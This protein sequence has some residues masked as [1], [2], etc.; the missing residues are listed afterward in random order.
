MKCFVLE[1]EAKKRDAPGPERCSARF[2]GSNVKAGGRVLRRSHCSG[3]PIERRIKRRENAD[4][5]GGWLAE[6]GLSPIKRVTE[7]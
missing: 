1:M 4:D 2:G 5:H 7:E 6:Q 3:L